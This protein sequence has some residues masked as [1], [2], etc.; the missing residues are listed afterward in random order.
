MTINDHLKNA[1]YITEFLDTKYQLLGIKIGID[2]FLNFI[3]LIGSFIGSLMSAYIL[4]IAVK[5][6]VKSTILLQ[7]LGNIL[8]DYLLGLIPVFGF[9]TDIVF[10]AN[11]RNLRLLSSQLKDDILEGVI[12][13]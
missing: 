6:Q 7:M 12:I 1:Q 13:P 8:I 9:L 10:K 5:M 4:W 3:P 2:P 11:V